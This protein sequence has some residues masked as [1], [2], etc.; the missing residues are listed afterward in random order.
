MAPTSRSAAR[1]RVRCVRGASPAAVAANGAA[2][3]PADAADGATLASMTD[4]SHLGNPS[5]EVFLYGNRFG[6]LNTAYYDVDGTPISHPLDGVASSAPPMLDDVDAYPTLGSSPSKP[7]RP[8]R[9]SAPGVATS[10]LKLGT[11]H[12]TTGR[13]PAVEGEPSSRMGPQDG[14]RGRNRR[15][16]RQR[17]RTA[18]ATA[19]ELAIAQRAADA[20]AQASQRMKAILGRHDPAPACFGGR[21]LA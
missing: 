21:R 17:K 15:G 19:R 6:V 14:G 7:T 3:A 10:M 9:R 20:R 11:V 4:S 5:G 2:A 1:S 12:D 16:R 13:H 8:P 18:I